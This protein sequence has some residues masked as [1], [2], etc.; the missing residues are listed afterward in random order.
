MTA[1]YGLRAALPRACTYG[2]TVHLLSYV[3]AGNDVD[4]GFTMLVG[5]C[6]GLV[7]IECICFGFRIDRAN[8]FHFAGLATSGSAE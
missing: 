4:A 3:T 1:S 5:T 8:P 2:H 7:T 6:L